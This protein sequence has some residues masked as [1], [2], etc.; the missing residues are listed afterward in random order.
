ML[1]WLKN[2]PRYLFAVL[3]VTAAAYAVDRWFISGLVASKWIGLPQYASAMKELQNESRNWGIA[4]LV[5]ESAALALS[6]PRWSKEKS[7][8]QAARC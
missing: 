8:S 3:V 7:R 2:R 5:L 1:L 6:L 4:A